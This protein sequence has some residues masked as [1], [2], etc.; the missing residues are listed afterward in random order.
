MSAQSVK[1]EIKFQFWQGLG[2]NL[3]TGLLYFAFIM[4]GAWFIGSTLERK[5]LERLATGEARLRDVTASTCAPEVAAREVAM[6]SGSVVVANDLFKAWRARVRSL[7][8]G[9]IPQY[10]SMVMRGR[11][12]ALLRL[13]VE[14]HTVGSDHVCGVRFQTTSIGVGGNAGLWDG[15][16]MKFLGYLLLTLILLA[17]LVACNGAAVLNGITPSSS[18]ERD[19][20]VS[21]GPL[22]RQSL[23]VYRASEPKAGAP[24]IVFV[25]GGGWEDGSKGLYKFVGDAFA[26]DGYDVVI[27]NYRLYPEASYESLLEDTSI[28]AAWAVRELGRPIVL[29]GHSAGGYN[30]LQSVFAPDESAQHG[31]KVCE[32]V[33]GVVALAAPTGAYEL[34]EEPYISVFPQR[35]LGDDAPLNRAKAGSLSVPP[36]LFIHGSDDTT[37]GPKNS[38]EL[39]TAIGRPEAVKLYPGRGHIDVVRLLSRHF[40]G[41]SAIKDDILGFLEGLPESDFCTN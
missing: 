22:E 27:P 8:G 25:H 12:E 13:K 19:K 6:V 21:Y 24:A 32:S 38:Q 9:A 18:F 23:D 33:A 28:A 14:A 36:I 3:G 4:T 7:F 17:G 16:L 10:E 35:F 15:Y 31:L 40:D 1:D 5:H 29:M 34:K 41:D 37:V 39:A 11:R 20:S 30:V 2:W 26:K